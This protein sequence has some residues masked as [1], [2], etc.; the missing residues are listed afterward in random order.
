MSPGPPGNPLS[1]LDPG[2]PGAPDIKIS[3]TFSL[4]NI[5]TLYK[6]AIYCEI[7]VLFYRPE[8]H[9]QKVLYLGIYCPTETHDHVIY[10]A[11]KGI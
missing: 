2:K 11:Y 7:K 8:E 6:L 9:G 10:M 1:P 5:C 3:V 4:K